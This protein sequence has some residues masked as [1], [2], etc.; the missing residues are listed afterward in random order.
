MLSIDLRGKTAVVTGSTVG[1]GL[2]IAKSLA[3]AGAAVVVNGRKQD[4]VDQ[5]VE[6]VRRHTPGASVQGVAAD[7]GT[8]EGCQQ[9]AAQ[10]TR[11]D[12]LVNN[13]GIYGTT[14]FLEIGDDEWQRY[15]DVN[16]MSGVRMSRAYMPQM[17]ERN[18]GR[19]VFIA[20]ES[21]LNIPADMVHYGT[22][23]TAMLGLARGL[24]KMAAGTGVTVN[25]VLP[26]PTL[27]EGA[28]QMLMA[29]AAP[30]QT[31]EEAGV[32]FVKQNRPSSIIGRA[33]QLEEVANMVAYVA[34]PLSS[35][36]TGAALR[37]EGGIVDSL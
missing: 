16:I 30:G 33:A 31:L 13:L 28:A 32:A 18:W 8:A 20:S 7:L 27:S 3:Q 9:L 15:W 11:C 19:V 2:A 17:L 34:S 26:G 4:A 14:P 29:T 10:A 22:S 21:A 1:I 24:A 6:A 23:K 25:S 5:A 37:V 12:I 36:T 35:A